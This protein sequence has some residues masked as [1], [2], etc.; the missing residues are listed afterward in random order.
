VIFAGRNTFGYGL[1]VV[2]SHGPYSTLYA[3]LSIINVSCGQVVSTGQQIGG[4]GQTGRATGPHLHFEI[5]DR[6]GNRSNPLA[7]IGL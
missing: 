5:M 6:S 1:A 7:T 4:V 2:I 3:H